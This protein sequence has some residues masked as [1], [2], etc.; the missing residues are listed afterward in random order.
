M[1]RAG[2]GVVLI[3][4]LIAGTAFAAEEAAEHGAEHHAGPPWATLLFSLINLAIFGAILARFLV[5]S[6]R[7]W[8]AERRELIVRELE[9][10]A[11]LR[12]EAQRLK[13][14]CDSRLAKLKDEI[15]Q[16]RA[17]ARRDAERERDRILEAARA[18][19]ANIQRDA[20]RLAAAEAKQLEAKLRAETAR[21]AVDLAEEK[22]KSSWTADDQQRLISEFLTRVRP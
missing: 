15:E 19:A 3:H 5:P 11:T 14:E 1:K 20:Q 22:I 13:A 2:L 10:A 21:R 16:M 6:I 7:S 18:T 17:E 12:A 4:L 9:A 8:V